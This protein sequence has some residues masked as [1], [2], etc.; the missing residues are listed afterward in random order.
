MA[1]PM[2]NATLEMIQQILRGGLVPA[3]AKGVSPYLTAD[4][5]NA[6]VKA[7][8]VEFGVVGSFGAIVSVSDT[9]RGTCAFVILGT[10]SNS[11]PTVRFEVVSGDDLSE[12]L[13][14]TVNDNTLTVYYHAGADGTVSFSYL[15]T[16]G[17]T[18]MTFPT[19]LTTQTSVTGT[20]ATYAAQIT[21]NPSG[22][23]SDSLE[24]VEIGGIIYSVDGTQ[25]EANPP[26]AAAQT[27]E[28]LEVEGV[29]YG[30]PQVVGNPQDAS[31]T[32]QLNTILIGS[33][34]Y[35]IP[36]GGGGS[37]VIGNPNTAATA[38]LVKIQIDGRTY[39]VNG[40]QV[41]ANP[42]GSATAE[43]DTIQIGNTVYSIQ[44][45]GGTVVVANPSGEA[46]G[47]L[48]KIQIGTGIYS[49]N[50]LPL[51]GGTVSGN[52]T[53]T[54]QIL[55]A[56]V[57]DG[58]GRVYSPGNKPKASDIGAL[59]TTGGTITGQLNVNGNIDATNVYA[60]GQEVYSPSN[61]PP[62]TPIQVTTNDD[63]TVN[64]VI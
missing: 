52:V 49:L 39:S 56:T 60:N 5:V 30:V 64:I 21:A 11:T 51:S 10:V 9:V 61:P 59:P 38:E 31:A 20:G 23:A 33:I 42:Q 58:S 27:L 18:G 8:Q 46:T 55:G 47:G 12:Y 26:G 44:G 54:G 28:K 17:D 48:T 53:V 32:Q 41:I 22:E 29:V 4:A 7:A 63:G 50:F 45:S 43:L 19:T 6:Y 1:N 37:T 36:V 40:T 16:M 2:N 35:S 15:T 3:K 57:W 13:V 14:Y 25:V 34:V 62:A 24:K